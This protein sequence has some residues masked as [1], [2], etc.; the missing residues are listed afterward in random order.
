MMKSLAL[1]LALVA[2]SSIVSIAQDR[3]IVDERPAITIPLPGVSVE[4][5][6]RTVIER[7]DVE[8]RR[9]DCDSKTVRTEGP[10]GTKTVTKERCD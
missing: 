2:A 6:D 8:K 4:R 10:E 5:R 7:R 3:V 9:G 1:S